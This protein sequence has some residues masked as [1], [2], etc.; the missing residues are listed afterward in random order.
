M[1][2]GEMGIF[3]QMTRIADRGHTVF[4][5]FF[6]GLHNPNGTGF[7]KHLDELMPWLAIGLHL[8][9]MWLHL[10]WPM[11]PLGDLDRLVWTQGQRS[12]I[13]EMGQSRRKIK[14]KEIEK[15]LMVKLCLEIRKRLENVVW[16]KSVR[17]FL[18]FC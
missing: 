10:V 9:G 14:K 7:R 16:A 8:D 4:Y 6:P 18:L 13:W 3:V 1:V 17:E 15:W 12:D 11:W 5:H 2:S